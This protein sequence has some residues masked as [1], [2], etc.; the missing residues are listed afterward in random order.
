MM[1][2]EVQAII[3]ALTFDKRLWNYADIARFLNR[4]ARTVADSISKRPDFPPAIR[5]D[6]HPLYHPEDVKKWVLKFKEKH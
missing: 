1:T 4:S 6:S 3:D 5:I 2:T